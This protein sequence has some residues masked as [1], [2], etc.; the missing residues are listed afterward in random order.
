MLRFVILVVIAVFAASGA[1]KTQRGQDDGRSERSRGGSICQRS[2]R[3]EDRLTGANDAGGFKFVAVGI[4]S[5]PGDAFRSVF[6]P[7]RLRCDDTARIEGRGGSMIR[8][9]LAAAFPVGPL[10]VAVIEPSLPALLVS[11]RFLPACLGNMR[12]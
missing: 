6:G 9:A 10:P 5:L 8:H 12:E 4:S 3:S 11:P 1:R 7:G 2:S